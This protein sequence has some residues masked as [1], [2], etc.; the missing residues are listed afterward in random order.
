MKN[1][2]E[3]QLWFTDYLSQALP[4]PQRRELADHLALCP[5]CSQALEAERRLDQL[6]VAQPLAPPPPD[7]TLQVLA[8]IQRERA[9]APGLGSW[10]LHGLPYAAS[11]V[12]LLVGLNRALDSLPVRIRLLLE[13]GLWGKW[14]VALLQKFQ[15]LTSL[16]GETSITLPLLPALSPVVTLGGLALLALTLYLS[17][18]EE[19]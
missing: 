3:F 18:A 7:F 19:H 12:A 8:C 9:P 6:L 11:A 15:A 5:A 4:T 13:P 10:L 2:E 1:C 14:Q 16:G 17:L